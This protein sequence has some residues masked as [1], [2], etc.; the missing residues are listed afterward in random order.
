MTTSSDSAQ[1][2]DNPEHARYEI[3]AGQQIAGIE[4]Y[5]RD[6]DVVTF[7]HTEI[8]P[9]FEGLGYASMLVS[10]ALDD[11]RRKGLR[12]R[13]ECRYVVGFLT[14]HPEYQDLVA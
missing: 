7:L 9:Q 2:R 10:A 5:S 12:V 6:G 13:P 4:K 3:L 14:K 11:L 1:V 8:Y